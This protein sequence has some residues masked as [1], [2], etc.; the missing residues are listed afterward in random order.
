MYYCYCFYSFPQFFFHQVFDW[1]NLLQKHN[2]FMQTNLERLMIQ[3]LHFHQLN[4]TIGH[5]WDH[6]SVVDKALFWHC[7]SNEMDQLERI[8]LEMK[9][10]LVRHLYNKRKKNK[11]KISPNRIILYA[12]AKVPL[13]CLRIGFDKSNQ[14]L[15]WIDWW[16]LKSILRVQT[17]NT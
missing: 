15:K 17:N 6:V 16:R 3:E 10:Q 8:S 11:L 12:R 7:L 14:Y 13:T 2:F 4:N 1:I 5:V 9:T